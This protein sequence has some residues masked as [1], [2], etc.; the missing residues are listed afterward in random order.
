MGR[1]HNKSDIIPVETEEEAKLNNKKRALLDARQKQFISDITAL[2]PLISD[3]MLVG[4]GK[5][6]GRIKRLCSPA[7]TINDGLL[8]KQITFLPPT[9][10]QPFCRGP[11][12][13]HRIFYDTYNQLPS[14]LKNLMKVLLQLHKKINNYPLAR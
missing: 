9:S 7:H 4:C 6:D 5:C 3:L 2:S 14:F 8:V 12:E 13:F 11:F 10:Q 1:Y